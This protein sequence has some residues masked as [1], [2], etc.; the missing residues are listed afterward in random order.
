MAC[1]GLAAL[2]ASAVTGRSLACIGWRPGPVKYLFAGWLIPIGYAAVTY[3]LAW[4][5]GIG[6][7]PTP[8]FLQRAAI[9][10]GLHD[11]SPTEIVL[12]AFRICR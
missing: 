2:A 9:T 6:A 11:K 12:S 7:I 1:A 8:L 5:T 10:L 3:G 4:I